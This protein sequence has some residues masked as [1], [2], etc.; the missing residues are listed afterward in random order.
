MAFSPG[1]RGNIV[2]TALHNLLAEGPSQDEVA[3]WNVDILDRRIGSAIDAALAE[4][5][6]HD[7]PVMRRLLGLERSRLR[8][9]LQSFVTA[10]LE[11]PPFRCSGS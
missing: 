3:A 1:M 9:L 10:E 5:F 7:D 4:H 11:R 6:L 2:H 8:Q